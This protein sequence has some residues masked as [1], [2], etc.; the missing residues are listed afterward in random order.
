MP[1]NISSALITALSARTLNIVVFVQIGFKSETVYVWSGIGNVTWNGQTWTGLGALLGFSSLTDYS[2]VTAKGITLTFSG[3]DPTLLPETLTDF[4]LAQPVTIYFALWSVAGSPPTVIDTPFVAWSG[5][6]DQPTITIPGTE[7]TISINCE[8][9]LIET[10][11]PAD[12]RYTQEDTQL[13]NP[14][15]LGCSFVDSIQEI[16]L[17]WGSTPLSTN[18]V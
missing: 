2:D 6:T 1:R 8:D 14:G 17:Y 18:N 4:Q 16:T 5:L 15:D 7:A 10:D 3:I 9:R 12:R 13:D 11:V